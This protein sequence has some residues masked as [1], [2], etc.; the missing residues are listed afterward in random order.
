MLDVAGERG[1]H[2]RWDDLGRRHGEYLEGVITLNAK[3]AEEVQRIVLAHELGHAWH[4]HRAA[5]DKRIAAR[6]EREADEHAATLLVDED[7]HR[8]AE[9]IYGPSV[10]AVAAELCIPERFVER[11]RDVSRRGAWPSAC[12]TCHPTP[13]RSREQVE[14]LV[15]AIDQ[16]NEQVAAAS[17]ALVDAIAFEREWINDPR[18]GDGRKAQAIH[19]RF[20]VT[21]TRHFQ[22]LVAALRS[23]AAW[24]ADPQTCRILKEKMDSRSRSRTRLA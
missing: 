24:A 4:D 2:V 9:R 17:Q 11:L 15:E 12:G 10:G 19:D 14:A 8:E 3:R 20:G 7:S 6:Q 23:P 5:K 22:R 21:E 13:G 16:S 1:I 18:A